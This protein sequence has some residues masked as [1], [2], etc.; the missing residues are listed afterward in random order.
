[1]LLNLYAVMPDDAEPGFLSIY[2]YDARLI[3]DMATEEVPKRHP[4][5]SVYV[6]LAKY[7]ILVGGSRDK[8]RV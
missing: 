6:S 7:N 2:L 5:G 8:T 1:M 4:S 3:T